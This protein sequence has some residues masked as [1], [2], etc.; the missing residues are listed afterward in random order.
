MK[1]IKIEKLVK[2]YGNNQVLKEVNLEIEQGDFFALLGHNGAGKTT[3]ISIMTN[4]VNKN[5]G[6]VEINGVDIDSDFSKARSF[7]G[8][9]PQEFN[10]DMFAKVKDICMT[11]AGYYG[12]S[13]SIAL[14]RVDYYLG[15]LGLAEKANA[16]AREL[17]GGMKRRLMIARALIHEPKI[18]VLDE[19]TAGVDV[20]LRQSMWEFIK[21]LNEKGT[22]ILLTTHYLEEVEALCKNV[23][24]INKGEIIENT[25]VKK[26]LSKLDEEIIVLDTIKVISSLDIEIIETFNA[27]VLSDNEIEVIIS[28]KHSL[29]DLFELLIKYDIKISSFRNK[30]NRLEKLFLDMTR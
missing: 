20:E 4:L 30:V 13:K 21:E 1:A 23:A 11:Q 27:R 16:K 22:T 9:V 6:K 28:K 25:S 8:V 26:L 18:L 19:P 5:S 3:M 12:I 17:S 7:I 24:I 10:F 15:K 29:N 2:N 14:K